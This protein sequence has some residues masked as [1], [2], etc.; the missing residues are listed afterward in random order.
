MS[1][2]IAVN[3]FYIAIVLI[4]IISTLP[5]KPKPF[6][7]LWEIRMLPLFVMLLSFR[8]KVMD[9]C[10]IPRFF[11]SNKPIQ[12]FNQ[13][14]DISKSI[15]SKDF[16]YWNS[17]KRCKIH[18]YMKYTSSIRLN[19]IRQSAKILLWTESMFYRVVIKVG[20]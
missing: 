19:P 1:S 8:A 20:L 17:D 4:I 15:W 2:V 14:S 16:L 7:L 18:V 5:Q 10:F 11:H 6:L 3:N 12:K 13:H 9:P